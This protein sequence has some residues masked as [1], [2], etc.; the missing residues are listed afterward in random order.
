MRTV[1]KYLNFVREQT[2]NESLTT[3]QFEIKSRLR[4]RVH[5]S[6]E[7]ER[8]SLQKLFASKTSRASNS[9]MQF[10]SSSP[11]F[12][13]KYTS[14]FKDSES[15]RLISRHCLPIDIQ[16]VIVIFVKVL[17]EQ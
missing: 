9:A 6:L 8:K 13:R 4:S 17:R 14:S 11:S 7:R 1:K 15:E 3:N 12:A 5:H 10:F 2:L 16:L